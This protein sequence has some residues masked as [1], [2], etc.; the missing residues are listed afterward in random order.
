ML[1]SRHAQTHS[2]RNRSCPDAPSRIRTCLGL[3]GRCRC[4]RYGTPQGKGGAGGCRSA[5]LPY[6]RGHRESITR[7]CIRPRRRVPHLRQISR[8]DEFMPRRGAITVGRHCTRKMKNAARRGVML[9]VVVVPCRGVILGP[10]LGRPTSHQEASIPSSSLL[11][12]TDTAGDS[13]RVHGADSGR[14]DARTGLSRKVQ[15]RGHGVGSPCRGEAPCGPLHR[16]D[17]GKRVGSFGP[18]SGPKACCV[19]VCVCIGL[20]V[21]SG[22]QRVDVCPWYVSMCLGMHVCAH[23]VAGS[24]CLE[25]LPS[26]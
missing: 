6:R 23:D 15:V 22:A 5:G 12:T 24:A 9:V 3:T 20:C 18:T 16:I 2:R 13:E 14:T 19:R 21:W 25:M 1:A 4:C 7:G 10:W 26:R 17:A 8:A 11:R